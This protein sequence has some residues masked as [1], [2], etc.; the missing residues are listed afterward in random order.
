MSTKL[1]E[2]TFVLILLL[3]MA[4][5]SHEAGKDNNVGVV[6]ST[7][8]FHPHGDM[9]DQVDLVALHGL[10]GIKVEL[11]ILDQGQAQIKRPGSIPVD[12]MNA[13]TQRAVRSEIGLN[14]RLKSVVDPATNQPVEFQAAVTALLDVL[15]SSPHKIVIITVGSLRDV[16]AAFNREPELFHRKL[17]KLLIFAGDASKQ[18]FIETNV[19]LDRQAFAAIM[20]AD[21]PIYWVPCFDGGRWQNRG[22]ASYWQTT[23]R[24]IVQNTSDQIQKYFIYAASKSAEDPILSLNDEI[25]ETKKENLF[26]SVRNLWGSSLFLIAADQTVIKTKDGYKIVPLANAP[27]NQVI[28]DF[29]TVYVDVQP[30][31]EIKYVERGRGNEVLRFRVRK[32]NV[33]AEIMTAVA[34]DLLIAAGKV[35]REQ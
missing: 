27:D 28:F 30:S 35:A 16:A 14:S 9:D 15:R 6:Y 12:Q 24:N 19:K 8:L 31:G 23:Y 3:A 34:N 4:G 26:S 2:A 29:T 17:D 32:K 1:V 25:N 20:N 7:D 5:C 18:D 33:Y 22:H 10:D 11:I 21:L 13:I